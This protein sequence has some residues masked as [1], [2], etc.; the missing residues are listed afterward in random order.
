MKHTKTV[1]CVLSV[2]MILLCMGVIRVTAIDITEE[3]VENPAE[4]AEVTV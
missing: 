4:L 1:S 3:S 2:V